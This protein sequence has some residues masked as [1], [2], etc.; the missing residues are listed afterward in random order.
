MLGYYRNPIN[1]IFFNEGIIIAAINSFGSD[2]KW[3]SGVSID[4]LYIRSVFLSRLLRRE[5]V[6][7]AEIWKEKREDYFDKILEK[8]I[9]RKIIAKNEDDKTGQTVIFRSSNETFIVFALSIIC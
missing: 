7:K 2:C 4:E 3:Q 5:E 8:M 9:E 1:H 6:Q